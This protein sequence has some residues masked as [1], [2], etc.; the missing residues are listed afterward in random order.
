MLG[1][2]RCYGYFIF[3]RKR[4]GIKYCAGLAWRYC[5]RADGGWANDRVG[6][7]R[8]LLKFEIVND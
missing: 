3:L 5:S 1:C 4:D 6:S 8:R 2:I 7:K